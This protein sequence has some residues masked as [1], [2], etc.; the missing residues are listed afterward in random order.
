MA[1]G[2]QPVYGDQKQ[3]GRYC[4]ERVGS[5]VKDQTGRGTGR[6]ETGIKGTDRIYLFP[7]V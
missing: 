1:G 7:A 5:A 2:L 6:K 3:P 4:L